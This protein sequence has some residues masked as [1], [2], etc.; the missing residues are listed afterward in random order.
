MAWLRKQGEALV[1]SFEQWN[2]GKRVEGGE[3]A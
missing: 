2:L 1:Q 3:L